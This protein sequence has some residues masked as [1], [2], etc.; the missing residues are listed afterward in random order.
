ML[1]LDL[2][3]RLSAEGEQLTALA[4]RELDETDAAAVRDAVGRARPEGVVTGAAWTAAAGTAVDAAETHE[5][6]ALAVNEPGPS[7]KAEDGLRDASVT[8][9]Q[10]C[11]LPI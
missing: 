4:R 10:T 11:A 9:V 2:A 8:G 7:I 1:G 5:A 6:E 3:E